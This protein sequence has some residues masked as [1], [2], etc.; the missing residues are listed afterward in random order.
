MTTVIKNMSLIITNAIY[1]G[2]ERIKD[3]QPLGPIAYQK[4]GPSAKQPA[5][6]QW[7]DVSYHPYCLFML[8]MYAYYFFKYSVVEEIYIFRNV[9]I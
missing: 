4:S 7:A 8:F 1:S 6:G 9:I 2:I 3:H 5:I